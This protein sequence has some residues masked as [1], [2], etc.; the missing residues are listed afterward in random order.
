MPSRLATALSDGGKLVTF[1]TAGDPSV[2]ELPQI[3]AALEEGGSDVIEIG[4][5]FSDPIADGPV[6]QASSQRALDRGTRVADVL[7]AV[8][9]SGVGVPLVLM[10][11]TNTVLRFGYEQFADMA[12]R[13]GVS[14]VIL[15]DLDPG[16]SFD[17]REAAKKSDLDTVFLAAP[18]STDERL[19]LV[20]SVS[21]GFVYCVSRTGVTG[22]SAG[23]QLEFEA[24]VH[25][26]RARTA[27]PLCVGFG[28]SKPSD[29]SSICSVADGAVVGSLLVEFLHT[30]WHGGR[31]RDDLV[32]LVASLKAAAR[33]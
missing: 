11:Y 18:T 17:W 16:D 25:R 2:G 29:V 26:L 27:L 9:E 33:E 14:G 30:R 10:G 32:E 4:L 22:A 28:V 19:E 8:G 1:V 5:P 13:A 7:G 31:G 20:A 24:L 12:R 21:T 15:S 23:G 3:L 6:I